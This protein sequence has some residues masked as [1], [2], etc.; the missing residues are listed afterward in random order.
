[1]PIY[2][3]Y[4]QKRRS[5]KVLS[6][7]EDKLFLCPTELI[8]L[9]ATINDYT[10]LKNHTFEWVQVVGPQ[11]VLTGNTPFV[12]E[13]VFEDSE[14]KVFRF[15]VDRGTNREQYKDVYIYYTPISNVNKAVTNYGQGTGFSS[16]KLNDTRSTKE[17]E[18]NITFSEKEKK[19]YSNLKGEPS[20]EYLTG[21]LDFSSYGFE[22][23]KRLTILKAESFDSNNY[24]EHLSYRSS[25]IPY[26][27][28]L[29]NGKYKIKVEY[30]VQGVE[31]EKV[32]DPFSVL[33][34]IKKPYR[35]VSSYLSG[36]SSN[37]RKQ[38]LIR[39]RITAYPVNSEIKE[40]K[41]V[42]SNLDVSSIVRIRPTFFGSEYSEFYTSQ[43]QSKTYVQNIV[44][45]DPSNIGSD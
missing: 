28:Y 14:D 9:K 41:W 15:Y 43:I 11:V 10:N 21:E 24:T 44:R 17:E 40:T 12:K 18:V 35:G 31:Q 16:F 33:L 22:S 2:V 26:K 20:F 32:S 36:M 19:V 37:T 29:L 3:G 5:I 38:N 30:A 23:V 8:E 7:G 1:M 45:T 4:T 13:F 25:E 34:Y 6:A 39:F 27:V 42:G